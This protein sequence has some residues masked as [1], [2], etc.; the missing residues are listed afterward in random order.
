M[1]PQGPGGQRAQDEADLWSRA[2]NRQVDAKKLARSGPSG[3]QA[4]LSVGASGRGLP[5][6]PGL[7]RSRE[8]V[9]GCSRSANQ[10]R[11]R[12]GQVFWG[13]SAQVFYGQLSQEGSGVYTRGTGPALEP[14]LEHDC[15]A[16]H[17]CAPL[18]PKLEKLG[19]STI[20][21]QALAQVR[22]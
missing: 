17:P 2:K 8:V 3:P 7:I 13:S 21:D 12:N 14:M 20:P 6:A 9:V 11:A 16:E 19:K 18:R 15:V 4:A 10:S 5:G 1:W 22:E